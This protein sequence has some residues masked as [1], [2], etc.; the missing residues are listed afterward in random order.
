MWLGSSV[1]CNRALGSDRGGFTF[2]GFFELLAVGV[3]ANRFRESGQEI[4]ADS[5]A[6]ALAFEAAIDE[7]QLLLRSDLGV[8][9]ILETPRA[10][11]NAELK[12]FLIILKIQERTELGRDHVSAYQH[13]EMKIGH[14]TERVSE[15]NGAESDWQYRRSFK[16]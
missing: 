9:T 3:V 8:G 5:Q 7:P 12:S 15:E 14:D 6:V 1:R 10:Y 11:L 16:V 13:Y 4:V 2:A